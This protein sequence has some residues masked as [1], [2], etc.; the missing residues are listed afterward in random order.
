MAIFFMALLLVVVFTNIEGLCNIFL[1]GLLLFV[2]GSASM[3]A[4]NWALSFA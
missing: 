4:Y 1:G 2:V 3:G